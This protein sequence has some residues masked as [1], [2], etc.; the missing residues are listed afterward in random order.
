MSYVLFLI[1]FLGLPLAAL[2]RVTLI[3]R[4]LRRVDLTALVVIA[5]VAVIYTTPWDNYLVAANV[6]YYNPDLVLKIVIGYVPSEEYTFF[7]LQTFLTGLFT[8]WLWQRFYPGDF[9]LP[10]ARPA[11]A[12]SAK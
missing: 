11:R 3:W 9:A 10:A 4:S 6:W 12:R 5:L 8:L 1:L 7:V 2:L